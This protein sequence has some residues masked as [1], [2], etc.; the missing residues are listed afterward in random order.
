MQ[1]KN[2]RVEKVQCDD[3]LQRAAEKMRELD[4]GSLTVCEDGQLVGMIADRDITIRA[5]AIG[6][7]PVR[8]TRPRGR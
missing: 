7:D 1:L 2:S 3:T 5:V 8:A 6:S 4:V